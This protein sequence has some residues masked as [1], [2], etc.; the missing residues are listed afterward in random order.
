MALASDYHLFPHITVLVRGGGDVASGVIY[1][2]HCAGFPVIVTEL[3]TPL[4]I[5]RAVSYGD[6]VYSRQTTVEGVKARL[7][8]SMAAA[9]SALSRGIVPVITE[10][11]RVVLEWTHPVIVVDGR[12]AKNRLDTTLSDAPLVIALG[13]GYFA[14]RDCHAIVETNSGHRLGRVIW[15]GGA[16]ADTGVPREGHATYS[17]ALRAPMDGHVKPEA[18]IGDFIHTGQIIARIGDEAIAALYNGVLRGLIHERVFVK[19][20][21]KIADLDFQAQREHCFTLS[22]RSLAIGGGVLEAVFSAPQM[23]PYLQ[24]KT[25]ETATDV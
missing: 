20:G 25:D 4:L 23:R 2:L 9:H 12:M 5:R 13:P 6:A 1:R 22:D 3:P 24:A 15:R 10:P 18:A 8:E 14:G 21:M 19:R 11:E 16:E 17:R 7:V